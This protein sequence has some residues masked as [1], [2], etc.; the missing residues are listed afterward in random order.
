VRQL[1]REAEKDKGDRGYLLLTIPLATFGLGCWQVQRR[2]W[3]LGLIDELELKTHADPVPFPEDLSTLDDLEYSKVRV[4]GTFDHAR[5]T[6]LGPRG[7]QQEASD[8]GGLMS[9]GRASVGMNVITAFKVKDRDLTIMVNRGWVPRNKTNPRNRQEG[10]VEGE[11]ELVGVVRKS[12]PRASFAPKND[13]NQKQ[14]HNRDLDGLSRE[15][16]TDRVFLDAV[17]E[18]TIPGGPVGGQTRVSLRNEHMSYIFT[19]YSLSAITFAM[20]YTKFFRK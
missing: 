13:P 10:Q 19:W 9:M 8:H 20:W 16:G 3:K 1:Q 15:L 5:E 4:R 6:Y 12:E 18:S 17:Y 11:V 14:W 2:K 7:L